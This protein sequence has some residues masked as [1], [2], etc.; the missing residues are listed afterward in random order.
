[1]EIPLNL[2]SG[3]TVLSSRARRTCARRAREDDEAREEALAEQEPD[4][5]AGPDAPALSARNAQNDNVRNSE[6]VPNLPVQWGTLYALTKLTDEQ[7]DNGIK[8]GAINPNMQRKDVNVL[9]GI[10]PKEKNK[11]KKTSRLL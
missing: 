7:F 4:Q 5:G 3:S 10:E 6:H 1:L 9:R 11:K 2:P 8:S